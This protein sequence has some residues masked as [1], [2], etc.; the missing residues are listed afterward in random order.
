MRLEVHPG[1]LITADGGPV[2]ISCNTLSYDSRSV[3]ALKREPL[4][5]DGNDARPECEMRTPVR[6]QQ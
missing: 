3:P 5:H 4:P 6:H 2:C 1:G